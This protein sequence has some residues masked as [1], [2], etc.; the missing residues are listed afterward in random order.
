MQGLF[1]LLEAKVSLYVEHFRG[2]G[3]GWRR[4]E[5]TGRCRYCNRFTYGRAEVCRRRRC[6]G[7]AP[8]WAGDQRR[9]LFENLKAFGVRHERV[10]LLTVTPPGRRRLAL[11]P[12]V[13]PAA[14]HMC[15]PGSAGAASSASRRRHGTR[16][17][18]TGGAGSTVVRT[19]RRWRGLAESRWS[20][21]RASGKCNVAAFCTCIRSLGMQ[22]PGSE[23][24][25][26]TIATTLERLR[27][28]YEFGFVAQ[29]ARPMSTSAAAAYLSAYFV[30]GK[31]RKVALHESVIA[32]GMPRSI[33]W[34][35]PRLTPQRV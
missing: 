21:W 35:S 16:R 20:C 7:Y 22:R 33:I 25:P 9:K 19:S 3:G 11:G 32:P 17:L 13:V 8:T 4:A 28:R 14:G 29:H 5:A 12:A 18:P 27:C 30:A 1:G 2:A 23:L 24:P 34:V 31:G 15:A 10:L 6:P 26:S